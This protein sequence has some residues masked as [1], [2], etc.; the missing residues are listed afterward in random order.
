M[1]IGLP[2]QVIQKE[3]HR[4][5][6][7]RGNEQRWIDTSL[8][9]EIAQG[10]WLLVFLEAAREVISAERAQQVEEA[11][12]AIEQVMSGQDVDI[13][14]CFADLTQREPELPEHLKPLLK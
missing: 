9:G 10:D 11:V 3:A 7:Q 14:A 5:L 8:V 2:Y 12:S 13:E 6:C 1:C 4:A